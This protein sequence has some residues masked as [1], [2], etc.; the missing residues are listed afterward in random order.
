MKYSNIRQAPVEVSASNDRVVA[1]GNCGALRDSSCPLG[2]AK[3]I[4]GDRDGQV[5]A[6]T[7]ERE[8]KASLSPPMID[9]RKEFH[10]EC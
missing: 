7:S 6:E 8:V 2:F 9:L 5:A 1:Q 3:S 4:E 10:R